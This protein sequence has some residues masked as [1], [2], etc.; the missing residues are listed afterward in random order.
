MLSGSSTCIARNPVKHDLTTAT[1]KETTNRE[2]NDTDTDT[3]TI[4]DAQVNSVFSKSINANGSEDSAISSHR[5][6]N[7]SASAA[8]KVVNIKIGNHV[9]KVKEFAASDYGLF[10]W[11]CSIVLGC[12]LHQ[13][14]QE[15]CMGLSHHSVEV[16]ED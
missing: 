7:T 15:L 4:K 6:S 1:C 14:R 10:I 3:D 9:L 5:V 2:R 16:L 13:H 8:C 11:P 12:Y